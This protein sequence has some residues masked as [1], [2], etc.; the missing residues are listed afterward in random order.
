MIDLRK[1]NNGNRV[2]LFKSLEGRFPSTVVN[3]VKVYVVNSGEN[4]ANIFENGKVDFL[5]FKDID[6][7]KLDV[8]IKSVVQDHEL[9]KKCCMHISKI[10]GSQFNIEGY[11][12]SIHFK[13][14][15][16]FYCITEYKYSNIISEVRLSH[17]EEGVNVS[18]FGNPSLLNILNML[19]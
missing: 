8:A 3:G 1:S 12:N 10:E 11:G 18:L 2:E 15:N 4:T 13:Y 7:I 5:G 9:I 16:G 6:E 17:D 19:N 14:S